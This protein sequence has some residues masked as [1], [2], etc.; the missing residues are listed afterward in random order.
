MAFG[1]YGSRPYWFGIFSDQQLGFGMWEFW[2]WKL[3]ILEKNIYIVDWVLE[4]G[5][6]SLDVVHL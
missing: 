5:V 4:V 2:A 6:L 1:N 3:G